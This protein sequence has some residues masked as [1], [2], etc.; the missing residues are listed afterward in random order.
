MKGRQSGGRDRQAARRPR[1][2]ADVL[3]LSALRAWPASVRPGALPVAL[4]RTA[5]GVA[6]RADGSARIAV[7]LTQSGCRHSGAACV[8]SRDWRFRVGGKPRRSP[9]GPPRQRNDDV[10]MPGDN[11]TSSVIRGPH[12][13][14]HSGP[15]YAENPIAREFELNDEV[16][17]AVARW[18]DY[19]PSEHRH[20]AAKSDKGA[21][22]TLQEHMRS[23]SEHPLRALWIAHRHLKEPSAS[24]RVASL[25]LASEALWWLGYFEDARIAAEAAAEAD[26]KSAQARW[27]LA[28]ALYRRGRFSDSAKCLDDLLRLVNRYGP[29]WALRGQVKVWLDPANRDAGRSD[30]ATAAKL[31]S[32]SGTW[33]VP[34]RME[35]D[36]FEAKVDEETRIHDSEVA[37]SSRVFIDVEWLPEKSRVENGVDPDRRWHLPAVSDSGPSASLFP[38]GGEW[39]AGTRTQLPP[40][41]TFVLYQRN[42]ENLSEDEE[43]AR[44]EIR[45]SVAELY[46]AAGHLGARIADKTPEEH[47]ETADVP[48]DEDR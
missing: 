42:I 2:G 3:A 13:S 10:P 34:Y 24:I 15:G 17:D 44:K 19:V 23:C 43:T 31:S 6:W 41:T 39:A 12:P 28:V 21:L 48:E 30:F 33:V 16:T 36:D 25:V 8:H 47:A 11:T 22:E 38:L 1:G 40:G 32:D 35:R 45:E 37:G 5:A 14:R 9:A 46:S 26:P 20:R 7:R 4:T 27:R 18:L 29:A